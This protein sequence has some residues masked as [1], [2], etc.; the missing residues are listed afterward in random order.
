MHLP[1]PVHY[2]LSFLLV[3]NLGCSS[4]APVEKTP[5]FDLLIG[6]YTD[7][8]EGQEGIQVY[9]FNAET[10]SLTFKNKTGQIDNPSYLAVAPDSKHVYA[11]SEYGKDSL[12]MVYGYAYDTATGQLSFI[13]KTF[14]GGQGP[15]YLA[16]DPTGSYLFTANYGDGKLG[17]LSSYQQGEEI[18]TLQSLNQSQRLPDAETIPSR[19][20]AT[21]LTPDNKFLVTTNLGLDQLRVYPFDVNSPDAPLDPKSVKIIEMP[22]N[23]GPRH[24]VF[25][26]NGQFGYLV[27]ELNGSV[28]VFDYSNGELTLKQNITMLP[29]NF[30][31]KSAAAD[32]HLSPDG[33]FLYAS[34]RLDLNEL[35]IYKIDENSGKLEYVDRQSTKGLTPRGFAIDPT[36]NYLLVGNQQ[37]NSLVVFKR[38]QKTG[39]L[40]DT[41]QTLS[42]KRPVNLVFIK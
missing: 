41:N 38:D 14:A 42:I 15:C 1:R 36:G 6:T 20:H 23:T 4:P 40:E 24:F 34:N 35:V 9:T 29:E 5:E 2:M 7:P 39:L 25:H 10:G 21:I 19:L 17:V 18:K 13:N 28:S 8:E 3:I 11:V 16:I 31:G 32:L 26:P 30:S 12:S 22:K 33:K 37:S 27:G